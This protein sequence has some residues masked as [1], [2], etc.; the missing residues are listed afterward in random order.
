M[1]SA[2][3]MSL[4]VLG[5][6]GFEDLE[7][8]VDESFGLILLEGISNGC[9]II[10][11][12]IDAFKEV[13]HDTGIYFKNMDSNSLNSQIKNVIS[14]DMKK[15]WSKQYSGINKFDIEKVF[16]KIIELYK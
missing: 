13:L 12:D 16:P 7:K 9:L 2:N 14:K 11:S 8:M 10:C 5:R 1:I 4:A 15:L 3:V 6:E